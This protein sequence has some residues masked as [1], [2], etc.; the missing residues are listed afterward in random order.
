MGRNAHL[1]PCPPIR[2]VGIETRRAH[3]R[4]RRWVFLPI[5]SHLCAGQ[6]ECMASSLATPDRQRSSRAGVPAPAQPG[7]ASPERVVVV[8]YDGSPASRAAIAQAARRA[9]RRERLVI[10]RALGSGF[11]EPPTRADRGAYRR[12]VTSLLAAVRSELHPNVPYELRVVAGD[13]SSALADVVRR[14]HGAALVT[15]DLAGP[16]RAHLN[17]A[18]RGARTHASVL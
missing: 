7:D 8:G 14:H 2:D 17:R 6:T 18:T 11:G 3:S 9:D 1:Q 5:A 10:V 15:E 13:L 4:R 12:A 16:A